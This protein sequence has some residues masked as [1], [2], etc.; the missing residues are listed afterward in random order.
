[1]VGDVVGKKHALAA[2]SGA[3]DGDAPI[4]VGGCEPPGGTTTHHYLNPATPTVLSDTL[5]GDGVVVGRR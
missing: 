2:T 4:V 5:D 1:M 3:P